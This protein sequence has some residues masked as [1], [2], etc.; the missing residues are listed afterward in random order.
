MR[1][2]F[3]FAGNLIALAAA[4]GLLARYVSPQVFWPPSVVALLLP[5]LLLATLVFMI[6][7]L[8]RG[9]WRA[10]LLPAI[11]LCLS[12]SIAGRLFAWPGDRL[13]IDAE[14]PTVT[15]LTGNQRMFRAADG[16]DRDPAEVENFFLR[17][18]ADVILMQE[19][20]PERRSLNYLDALRTGTGH[21]DRHQQEKTYM[22]TYADDPE[23]VAA[24]FNDGAYNGILVTDVAT[25]IGKIRFINTHL[26][27]NKISNMAQGIRGEESV[28]DQLNTLGHMF[29][30]YG[31]TTR[32][33]AR[34]AEHIRLL[35]DESP[36]PVI[37][38]GDFNDV[39]SSYAYNVILSPRLQDAWAEAGAG[40]GTTFTGPIPGLR[41]DYF[42]VDTALQVVH[43]KQLDSPWSDHRMLK[44]EVTR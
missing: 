27:S 5:V 16:R 17:H 2:L 10:A 22:A 12:L 30:G 1:T 9:R 32:Q 28:S 6:L 7:E 43:I 21:A 42:L 24:Y 11:V 19:V 44:L 41:I 39:P 13:A 3:S 26:R 34:Q 8:V 23:E 31:R 37:L 14:A 33:R 36:Y 20:W 18:P 15:V 4:F 40:L 29:A 35:V 25:A 38:G